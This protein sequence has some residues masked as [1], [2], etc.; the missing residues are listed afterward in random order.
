MMK[1][2]WARAY[3]GWAVLFLR[4]ATGL[5]FLMHGWQK[6]GWG[7][8]Q[9]AGFLGGLGFPAPEFFAVLL[10]AGEIAAGVGLILGLFTRFA[11]FLAAFI[12]LIALLTVHLTK[13][14]FISGG[15]FEF[16]LLIL[17]ASLTFFTWGADDKS[18]DA[19]IGMK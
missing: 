18:V 3:G 5:V 8:A 14:F 7:V 11:G 16:I 10:I 13:G 1:M 4:V 2:E 17:A 6:L 12:A 9:V 19:M 15:G